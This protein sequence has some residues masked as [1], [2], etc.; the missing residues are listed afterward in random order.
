MSLAPEAEVL[1]P[2]AV[3]EHVA[4]WARELARRHREPPAAG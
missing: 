4:A 3:R 1:E 2:A